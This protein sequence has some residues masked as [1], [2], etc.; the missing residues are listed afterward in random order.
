MQRAGHNVW[1]RI[2]IKNKVAVGDSSLEMLTFDFEKMGF[3]NLSHTITNGMGASDGGNGIAL[4]TLNYSTGVFETVDSIVKGSTASMAV[5]SQL[6][7]HTTQNINPAVM[8]DSVCDKF[9]WER[10]A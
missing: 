2:N 4:Y 3:K 7:F 1:L 6:Y 5:D 9:Y 10:T 8:D